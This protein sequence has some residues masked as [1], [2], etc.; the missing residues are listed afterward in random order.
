MFPSI[1]VAIWLEYV[2][3]LGIFVKWHTLPYFHF[4]VL[5]PCFILLLDIKF[6]GSLEPRNTSFKPIYSNLLRNKMGKCV[7]LGHYKNM[8][9]YFYIHVQFVATL[10]VNVSSVINIERNPL[11][12]YRLY[13]CIQVVA[14]PS[15]LWPC[16]G[17]IRICHH[18]EYIISHK[19]IS[20]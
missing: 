8:Y 6:V 16:I 4:A 5:L 20:W 12:I 2:N 15:M 17:S 11:C 1:I 14:V 13:I 18:I 19:H 10:G 7:N 3:D 9:I